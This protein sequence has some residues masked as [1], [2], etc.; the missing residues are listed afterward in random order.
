[1]FFEPPH[2]LLIEDN[3]ND[4][5]LLEVVLRS[6]AH[7]EAHI[8]RVKRL[9]EALSRLRGV[10]YDL[11]LLDLTLPDERGLPVFQAVQEAAPHLP[12]VIL[13]GL[14]DEA[15]ASETVRL[16]AQDYLVKHEVEGRTLA[17]ALTHA[18]QRK[19]LQLELEEMQRRKTE[20]VAM[21]SHEL[22]NP[23]TGIVGFV[24]LLSKTQLDEVQREYV[25]AIKNGSKSL[26]DLLNNL[27]D[28]S[29]AESGHI[30]MDLQPLDLRECL[31]GVA[32][33]TAPQ[34]RAK[35][36]EMVAS[37]DPRIPDE[38][39]ADNLR[40]RQVLINLLG[41][42]LKF[43]EHGYVG[44]FAR[45]R[46][47]TEN[48]VVVRFVVEDS[49]RGIPPDKRASIF[50]AFTQAHRDDRAR[51]AGLG[52]AISQQLIGAM[53]GVLGVESQLGEGT[54]FWFDLHFGAR[55]PSR[56]TQRLRGLR[57]M[58]QETQPQT[59][60]ALIFALSQMGA[61]VYTQPGSPCDLIVSDRPVVRSA[62][63][64]LVCSHDRSMTLPMHARYISRPLRLTDL[65]PVWKA[66]PVAEVSASI[67]PVAGRVLVVEDD[68]ICAQLVK[69]VSQQCGY[70][71]DH[72]EDGVQALNLAGSQHYDLILLDHHLPDCTGLELSQRLRANGCG[73]PLVSL[74]G[75]HKACHA[76]FQGCL[77]KPLDPPELE[78]LLQRPP[79]VDWQ[80]L[81]RFKKFQ[82]GNNQHLIREL[83]LTF[84]NS[85]SERTQ[86]LRAAALRGSPEEVKR[87]AHLLKGAAA[88]VGAV[89]VA[90]AAGQLEEAPDQPRL[91]QSLDYEV[92]RSL[93]LFRQ[94]LEDSYV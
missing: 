30:S 22:R 92:A 46:A 60:E 82:K 14:A 5:E 56:L 69:A 27:L 1:M 15:L 74:S 72:A 52:L 41:N 6:E 75:S 12:I 91:I 65:E 67:Q 49:G 83:V 23:M 3:P 76:S 93:L 94:F 89:G 19:K 31:E 81:E 42:A 4:A 70:A 62:I 36:L 10:S 58:V 29:S 7:A 32:A 20:F 84:T 54:A 11:I 24:H 8:E 40:L 45:L 16:G 87:V 85:A 38:V 26:L 79:A 57:V 59:A 63:P 64:H 51:G 47:Q 2:I 53:G 35:G 86:T 34:A 66:P 39:L 17:R 55:K 90:E 68:L 61:R 9:G 44:L 78:K 28:L 88:S 73:S 50:Q 37:I 77:E 71:C 80:V 13:T 48:E 18:I 21:V 43:T 33:F 25:Q